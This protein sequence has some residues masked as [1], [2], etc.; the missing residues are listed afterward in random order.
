LKD[1]A[2][3][4]RCALLTRV[5]STLAVPPPHLRH[6]LNRRP[7]STPPALALS[8]VHVVHPLPSLPEDAAN[9]RTRRSDLLSPPSAPPPPPP[10]QHTHTHTPTLSRP[11]A[12]SVPSSPTLCQTSKSRY[13]MSPFFH[14]R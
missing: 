9:Y 1:A 3:K 6:P 13:S 14:V 11:R 12:R 7:P 4:C 2:G 8:I 10:P 5:S